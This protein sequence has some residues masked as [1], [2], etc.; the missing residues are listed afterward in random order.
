MIEYRLY[1]I[2]CKSLFFKVLKLCDGYTRKPIDL[3]VYPV[4]YNDNGKDKSYDC[5][6]KNDAPL[7]ICGKLF[8]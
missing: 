2:L 8:K 4:S 1:V 7:H 3:F 6:G 5:Q